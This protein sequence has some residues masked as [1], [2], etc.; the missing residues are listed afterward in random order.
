[1]IPTHFHVASTTAPTELRN[2][3]RRIFATLDAYE[4]DIVMRAVTSAERF[5][6]A[7]LA[8]IATRLGN[9]WLY[10]ILT[11]VLALGPVDAPLRFLVAATISLLIA[12]IAY[13]SMKRVLGRSRPCDYEPSLTRDLAPLDHYSCPSGHAMTA[14]AYGIPLVFACPASAPFVF[15]VCSV[16]GWSRVALGH[17]YVSDILIGTI[18]GASIATTVGAMLY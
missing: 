4:V 1:M 5:K 15:A 10:P 2:R 6:L 7:P 12:F 16:I 13:P 3:P 17:H 11:I 8:R 9:G 18:I 14:A